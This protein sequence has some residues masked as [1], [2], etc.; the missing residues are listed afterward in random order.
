MEFPTQFIG[1][2][3]TCVSSAMFSVVVNGELQGYFKGEKEL[4]QGDPI[5]VPT[6]YGKVMCSADTRSITIIKEA[7]DIFYHLSGLKPNMQKSAIFVSGVSREVIEEIAAILPIPNGSL[8]VKYLGVP[9]ISSRLTYADRIQLEEKIMSRIQ[10]WVNRILGEVESLLMGFLWSG[11][12]LM[13]TSAK[14]QW[15][16]VCAIKSEGGL[17]FKPLELYSKA[18]MI[19]FQ[20]IGHSLIK[21]VVEDGNDTFLW[22]DNCHPIGPPYRHFSEEVVRVLGCSLQARVSSIICNDVW[23]W[24][25]QRNRVILRNMSRTPQD[26]KPIVRDKVLWTPADGRFSVKTAWKVIGHSNPKVPW[27]YVVW[28]RGYVSRWAFYRLVLLLGKVSHQGQITGLGSGGGFYLWVVRPSEWSIELDWV[29]HNLTSVDFEN[30][31]YKLVMSLRRIFEIDVVLGK[32]WRILLLIGSYVW[33]GIVA[34]RYGK[35]LG[36]RVW[37]G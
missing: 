37:R 16:L 31:L 18:S 26:F 20:D 13:K 11:A 34:P 8:H 9:L 25:R 6:D 35:S 28:F 23:V 22:L 30:N 32:R 7:L 5:S 21:H 2:V 29:I 24:P 17:G 36:S 1:W 10:S 3:E 19:R 33:P 4:R 27:C 12:A 15:S 14:F